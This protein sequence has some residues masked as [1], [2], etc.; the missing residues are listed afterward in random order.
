MAVKPVFVSLA[1]AHIDQI[2]G[3][4]LWWYRAICVGQLPPWLPGALS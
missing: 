2:A 3:C 4:D 1:I